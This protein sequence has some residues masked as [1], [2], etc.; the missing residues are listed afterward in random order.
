MV[1]SSLQCATPIECGMLQLECPAQVGEQQ[2]VPPPMPTPLEK[3]SMH[4]GLQ[5]ATLKLE[6]PPA[7]RPSR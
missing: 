2:T 5:T 3:G 1:K 7:Q 6:S 4:T